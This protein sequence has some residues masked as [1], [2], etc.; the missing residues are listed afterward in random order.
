MAVGASATRM[1]EEGLPFADGSRGLSVTHDALLSFAR[2][3][4]ARERS[5]VYLS[6]PITTGKQF[7]AWRRTADGSLER[8]HPEYAERH[9]EQVVETNIARV[10]PLVRTLRERF[11]GRLV[12]DPTALA[13]VPGWLQED[14]HDLWCAV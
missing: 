3:L 2:C 11:A 9:R 13:G 8:D 6:A 14:Y 1:G 12:I 10:A 5:E 7:V 4:G